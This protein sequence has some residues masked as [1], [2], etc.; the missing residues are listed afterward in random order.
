MEAK[1][2]KRDTIL[3]LNFGGQYCHLIGRRIREHKVYTE[4]VPYDLSIEELKTLRSTLNL[5]GIVL[6]GGPSSVFEQGAPKCESWLF[7]LRLPVLGICYGHQLIAQMFGGRVES[8][9][10]EYGLTTVFVDKPVSVL[11]GLNARERVWMS[12]GDTVSALPSEFEVLAHTES[13][14][15]AAFSHKQKSIYGLQW[16]PE[17]SHTLKGDLM[18]KNFICSVCG[19]DENWSIE[20][21]V[22]KSVNEIQTAVGDG[23]CI[24]GLSGG[25]DS[26]TA[27]VL[28]SKA[29]GKRLTAVFVD[30]G[31]M[32]CGEPEFIRKTFADFD[33][34]LI[35]L[36]EKDRFLEK[37]RGVSDP[38]SKRK[39]I[40]EEFVR[41]FEKVARE[42]GS[43][44]L[45]QGTIYV[46]LAKKLLNQFSLQ[47]V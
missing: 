7:S 37:L 38:E 46:E 3:I 34:I 21:F 35:T 27:T 8:S 33:I 30:H 22:D 14:P 19:C 16:H 24:V 43:E 42:N 13:S 41:V 12:H 47:F 25:V 39:I 36:Y 28:A 18:L 1:A 10:K 17:V 5:K 40:G 31:F 9:A 15:V 44:Y 29:I 26:S 2:I 23:K 11:K 32:R 45:L 4:L 6:S 20:D